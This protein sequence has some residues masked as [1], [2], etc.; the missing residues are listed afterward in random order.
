MQH[1][2]LHAMA[3][4]CAVGTELNVCGQRESRLEC[5]CQPVADMTDRVRKGGKADRHVGNSGR[6]L[7]AGSVCYHHVDFRN[8]QH[9]VEQGK[10]DDPAPK[11][12]QLAESGKHCHGHCEQTYQRERSQQAQ[13]IAA[14]H[15]CGHCI[16][17]Q[18]QL[19]DV[20]VSEN[21][22]Y[23]RSLPKTVIEVNA[24]AG[25]PA[26]MAWCISCICL[27]RL[28]SPD[29]LLYS[30]MRMVCTSVDRLLNLVCS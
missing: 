17:Y 29:V 5:S 24:C 6:W 21:L 8:K 1:L 19:P 23:H 13:I 30:A 9:G 22:K 7:G 15:N 2:L 18:L 12:R 3:E 11:I 16:E 10:H 14:T 4:E 27:C 25:I 26:T 20:P 28:A